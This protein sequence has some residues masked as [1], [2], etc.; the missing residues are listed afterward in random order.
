[1]N[2][3]EP[4]AEIAVEDCGGGVRCSELLQEL[5]SHSHGDFAERV[6]LNEEEGKGIGGFFFSFCRSGSGLQIESGKGILWVGFM[7]G[8]VKAQNMAHPLYW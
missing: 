8:M 7:S 1:M 3:R 2:A 4:W 5:Q 6:K